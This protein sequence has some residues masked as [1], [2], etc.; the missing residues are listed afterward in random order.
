V[1]EEFLALNDDLRRSGWIDAEGESA[2]R[3]RIEAFVAK[4]ASEADPRA[5][6]YVDYMRRVLA[7]PAGEDRPR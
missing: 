7:T 4:H 2:L 1:L 6:A 3:T 5:V